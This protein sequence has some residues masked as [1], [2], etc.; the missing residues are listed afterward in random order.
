MLLAIQNQYL[1]HRFHISQKCLPLRNFRQLTQAFGK[2]KCKFSNFDHNSRIIPRQ[3]WNPQELW[4]FFWELC[5]IIPELSVPELSIIET[6]H[7]FFHFS[8][9][10]G[11]TDVLWQV[12]CNDNFNYFAVIIWYSQEWNQFLQFHN[13]QIWMP[14]ILEFFW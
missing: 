8:R 13:D 11:E 3:N 12:A 9:K 14:F 1:Q 4:H 10:K 7:Y 2:Q 6:P 5:T